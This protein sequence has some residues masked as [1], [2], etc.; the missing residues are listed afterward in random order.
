MKQQRENADKHKTKKT[1][2]NY[3]LK[4]RSQRTRAKTLS[5]N[6][7]S[8]DSYACLKTIKKKNLFLFNQQSTKKKPG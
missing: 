8:T 6:Q 3:G 5:G 1:N 4:C 7:E 2:K